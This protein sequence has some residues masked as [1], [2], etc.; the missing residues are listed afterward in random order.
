[1]SLKVEKVDVI[2]D[3]SP[4][5]SISDFPDNAI[6]REKGRNNGKSDNIRK[7]YNI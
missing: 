4:H 1:M 7:Y 2:Y 6:Q 3:I 5:R